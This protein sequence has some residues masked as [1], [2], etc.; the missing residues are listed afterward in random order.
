[1][2]EY[3]GVSDA[4]HLGLRDVV[5]D[6]WNSKDSVF[7]SLL[8]DIPEAVLIGPAKVV[9]RTNFILIG[10][11]SDALASIPLVTSYSHSKYVVRGELL[12]TQIGRKSE[13]VLFSVHEVMQIGLHKDRLLDVVA[14]G[15]RV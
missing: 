10:F 13:L 6:G 8:S 4:L 2:E 12:L 3:V 11:S 7:I 1:M 15:L 5:A 14:V 9:I